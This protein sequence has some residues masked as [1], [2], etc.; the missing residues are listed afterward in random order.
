MKVL[1]KEICE[2]K[3]GG[4]PKKSNSLFYGGK[5]PWVTISDFK[6]S[7]NDVIYKTD[8]YLTEDGLKEINNRIF[9]KGGYYGLIC[10]SHFGRM[11][12]AITVQMMPL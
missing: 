12:P 11:V 1:F 3:S 9:P 5:I 4:T 6:N 7:V 2:M 8:Q 10:A